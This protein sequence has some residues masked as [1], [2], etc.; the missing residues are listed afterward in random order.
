MRS[1]KR[2]WVQRSEWEQGILRG[3]S[4]RW[5]SFWSCLSH[6]KWT[7]GC[8]LGSFEPFCYEP[9]RSLA[10]RSVERKAQIAFQKSFDSPIFFNDNGYYTWSKIGLIS[11]EVKAG[12]ICQS[13]SGSRGCLKPFHMRGDTQAKVSFEANEAKIFGQGFFRETSL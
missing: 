9:C 11:F 2:T 7:P 8:H 4:Q 1:R 6:G 13:C 3:M 5:A 10:R 12:S